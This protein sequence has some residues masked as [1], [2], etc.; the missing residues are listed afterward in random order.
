ME[1]KYNKYLITYSH[2]KQDGVSMIWAKSEKGAR[3]DWMLN[4]T[5]N[6]SITSVELIPTTDAEKEQIY[7]LLNPT[8]QGE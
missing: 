5:R 8:L 7:N 4:R 3:R 6:F 2:P 1:R